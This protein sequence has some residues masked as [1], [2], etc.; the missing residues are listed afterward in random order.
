MKYIFLAG[1]FIALV[2]LACNK[3]SASSD[4]LDQAD[5]TGI[6]ASTNTYNLSIKAILNNNCA[7]SGCHDASTSAEGIDLSSYSA[8]KDAFNRTE[9]LCSIHHGS[10]C[11]PMPQDKPQLSDSDINKIDCWVKNGYAE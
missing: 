9:C 5:C 4:Y 2:A 3:D 8:A 7:T 11:T 1:F 10:G 6:D